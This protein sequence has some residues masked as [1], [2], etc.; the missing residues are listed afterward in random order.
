MNREITIRKKQIKYINENDYNRIF[1]ISDLHG[2]Y[3]LFLKFIEKVNLQKDDLLINL[4]DSCDRGIQSYELYLKYDEMIK[5]GYNV[6]H[7]LGNH[8]DM[9]LTTV[10]TLDYDKMIHW[11]INGGKKTIESFKRVTGLSIEN[12]FDLEKNKFLID[13]LSSFPTLI[14]SNKSIFTH[15]AY[16]PNLPPEKQE[17]YFLI[18]NRENFWDRNK[19]GKAIYFGH[20]PSRKEDHTIVYYPN[21]C[22]CIDLG[23]YRYN[24]MGGIEIKSKKEYYIEILY[25]GDNNRRF[26]LGEVTGDKPLICF[27]VNP[28]KA[29]IVDGKLQTDKTIEKIRHIVD[30]ENYDGWIMLNLYPEV[31]PKPEELKD[32][33]TELHKKNIDKIKEI[34]KKYPNSGILACW[35]NLINK[36]DYLKYCLKGLKKDNFKDYSLLGEVNGIIEITKNRKW[37]HIGSLTKKGNPR[38]PLYVSIDANLEVF[39]IKNYIENL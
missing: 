19:T 17:E 28:S 23:T 9:L 37:Y 21:N 26:V 1:V 39:N 24:K 15:A 3:E 18:W 30:M 6:L 35:G 13:F 32:F 25:Q 2:N 33:K 20:T 8:E 11:F 27:G 7:I 31:T 4:G 10:N 29:K 14:I 5:Q 16:N 34:L 22:T 36:R 12:F 38:H